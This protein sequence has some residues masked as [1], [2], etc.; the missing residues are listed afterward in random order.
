MAPYDAQPSLVRRAIAP[1]PRGRSGD[2]R[3][4]NSRMGQ[5][6]KSGGSDMNKPHSKR[7]RKPKRHRKVPRNIVE[8][9]DREVMDTVFGKRVMHKV[10]Q[11]LADQNPRQGS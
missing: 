7:K 6:S 3:V 5:V 1:T 8:K 2:R 9:T 4:L 10:D 11:V